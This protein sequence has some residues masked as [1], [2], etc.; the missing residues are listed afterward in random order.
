MLHKSKAH[1]DKIEYL[2]F[3]FEEQEW[4]NVPVVIPRMRTHLESAMRQI[5]ELCE[6]LLPKTSMEAKAKD[7]ERNFDDVY[8]FHEGI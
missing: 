8:T 7:I 6:H 3:A 5:F 1:V 2:D 4:Q